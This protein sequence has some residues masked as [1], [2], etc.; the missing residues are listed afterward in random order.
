MCCM[1]ASWLAHPVPPH[2]QAGR[3]AQQSAAPRHACELHDARTACGPRQ[4][5]ASPRTP[6]P[7]PP[8]PGTPHSPHLEEV[9][10]LVL[11]EVQPPSAGQVHCPARHIPR[12]VAARHIL[13]DQAQVG[14]GQHCRLH[15][16]LDGR[17]K[18]RA[19][20]MHTRRALGRKPPP[21]RPFLQLMGSRRRGAARARTAGSGPVPPGSSTLLHPPGSRGPQPAGLAAA[22]QGVGVGG[23]AKGCWAGRGGAGYCA[24]QR[25]LA[26]G[27]CLSGACTPAKN[28]AS[29]SHPFFQPRPSVAGVPPLVGLQPPRKCRQV[30]L[31]VRIHAICSSAGELILSVL[32]FVHRQHSVHS[33]TCQHPHVLLSPFLE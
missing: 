19:G 24:C 25:Q 9:A 12:E 4:P 31:Q 20:R 14:G 6:S 33:D 32:L 10:C 21:P 29:P 13:H 5:L 28:M 15:A 17:G 1:Q 2:P 18:G 30:P 7:S 27:A 8:L 22:V 26:N 3:E 16:D 23:S 11:V